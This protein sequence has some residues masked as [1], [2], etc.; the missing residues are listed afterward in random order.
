MSDRGLESGEIIVT[1]GA[2]VLR[3]DLAKFLGLQSP[4]WQR[5]PARRD[6]SLLARRRAHQNQKWTVLFLRWYSRGD[7]LLT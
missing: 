6:L 5:F 4:E 1:P 3:D 7:R 2:V